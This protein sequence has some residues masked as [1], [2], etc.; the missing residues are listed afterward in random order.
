LLASFPSDLLENYEIGS[1]IG[2]GHYSLVR[3]C[4]DI[5]TGIMFAVKI[6][7]AKKCEEK[8]IENFTLSKNFNRN[9]NFQHH[10]KGGKINT[11]LE[12]LRKIKHINIIK[13]VEEYTTN[14]KIFLI[15]E[16]FKVMFLI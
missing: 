10:Q 7:D 16:Y 6:I 8:V 5:N 13:L 4:K 9:S 12:I 14:D 2:E 11:E 1:V 15:M 3:E